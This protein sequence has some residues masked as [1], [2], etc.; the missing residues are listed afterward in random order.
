M[1]DIGGDKLTGVHRKDL[2]PSLEVTGMNGLL[3]LQAESREHTQ[4]TGL[5]NILPDIN[6][7][8]MHDDVES[9][10]EA[11]EA[12]EAQWAQDARKK[13]SGS[14]MPCVLQ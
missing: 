3:H 1:T 5:S 11:L 9:I 12:R 7:C 6:E 8:F 13:M 2:C 10:V 4:P 14:V